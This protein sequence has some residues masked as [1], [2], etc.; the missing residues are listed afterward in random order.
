[1]FVLETNTGAVASSATKPSWEFV[2][3]GLKADFSLCSPSS[4][5]DF[6]LFFQEK[7]TTARKREHSQPL[8]SLLEALFFF[9]FLFFQLEST[10]IPG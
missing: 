6:L 2:A 1:M 7:T 9:F 4:F 5:R 3:F 8:S 10:K